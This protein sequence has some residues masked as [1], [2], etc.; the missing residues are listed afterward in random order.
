M[1][2]KYQGKHVASNINKQPLPVEPDDSQLDGFDD[3]SLD[4][5]ESASFDEAEPLDYD[6]FDD[7]PFDEFEAQRSHDYFDPALDETRLMPLDD[8]GLSPFGAPAFAPVVAAGDDGKDGKRKGSKKAKGKGGKQKKAKGKRSSLSTAL[9]IIGFLLLAAAIA[10]GIY[11]SKDYISARTKYSD[12][13]EAAGNLEVFDEIFDGE[14]DLFDIQIDWDALK[15]KNP[16]IVGWIYVENT[17]INYPVVQAKDNDYYLTHNA[18]GQPSSSGAIFLDYENKLD[19]SS[20]VN[21]IYGHNMMD[22]SMFADITKF[23]KQSF[24]DQNNRIIIVTPERAWILGCAFTYIAGGDEKIRK[25]D[26]NT[27]E[28]LH[29]YIYKMKNERA[30]TTSLVNIED[31]D[32]LFCLVTCSYESND[33]RT[34]LCAV[35]QKA[36]EFPTS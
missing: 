30:V 19:M 36:I 15:E 5:F 7:A 17:N 25:T 12:L 11:I 16:D 27:I 29:S 3:A 10:L 33:V 24:L 1:A 28:D 23:K 4:E 20:D 34:I 6:G 18:D 31:I 9:L 22:G 8:E 2:A 32:K 21:F 35:E 14:K 13:R 26:F